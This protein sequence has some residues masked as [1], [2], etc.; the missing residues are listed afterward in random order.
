M[1]TAR[2][3]HGNVTYRRRMPPSRA[4]PVA[5]SVALALAVTTL[6]ATLPAAWPAALASV[7][8]APISS[9]V[10]GSASGSNRVDSTADPRLQ[11]FYDQ[12]ITWRSCPGRG[13]AVQC[14]SVTVPLDY[15]RPAG[16]SIDLALLKVPARG[17]SP[18]SLVVNPGGPGA[19]GLDF[20]EYLGA[21]IDAD[22]RAAYDI[23]GFDPRGVGE[24]APV[25]CMT[26]R[27][28]TR[29]YRTDS[30][31]DTAQERARLMS[32]AAQI[33]QGCVSSDRELARF[34]GT[35][36]TVR[37]MDI[38]RSALGADDLNWLGFSYGTLLGAL[39]AQEFPDRVGRMVL[40]GGV[41]PSLD[42]VEVSKDQSAGFQ[43][44]MQ[45]FAADCA[46][47]SDCV[48]RTGQGVLDRINGLLREL[49]DSSLRTD[50]SRRLVQSEALTALFF[51][52]YSTDLWPTL[53]TGLRQAVAGDG[54]TLQL[55]AQLAN[56]QVGPNRYSSNIASAFY[57]IG[58]W[59]Y[60]APPDA[61]G[62]RAAAAE[63]SRGVAVP[64]MGSAM[65]WGNAPCSQWF[66][67]AS[68]PPAEV[69]SGTTAPILVIGTTFD[70]A[71]PYVWS[72]SL[73]RQLPTSTLLTYRGD[74]HTAYGDTNLCID[75]I[76]DT[77]LL[78]AEV[79]GP[80]TACSA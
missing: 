48:A 53:R 37:D 9:I 33:S 10:E 26:G 4:L 6:P 46:R 23:I 3:V 19:S 60:P 78:T 45:R 34:V 16:R 70:P 54:T 66:D 32:R 31:P 36:N 18:A 47:K 35:D 61:A 59:D 65:S 30:T 64:E 51:S 2:T 44:A 13:P 58:C 39:Y 75:D 57:A 7:P 14:A 27:Q 63:W 68:R 50:G 12:G 74:G 40:D 43:R 42:A 72:Q 76:V 49:D 17:P 22:V 21:V 5:V 25:E 1:G 29:W 28:T 8:G 56:N 20:A 15:Q 80:A 62:L 79:P 38:I 67:H 71:T 11:G 69:S 52:M 77:Y 55:L 73:A 41:D 24:S